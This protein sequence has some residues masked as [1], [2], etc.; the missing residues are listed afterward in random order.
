MIASRRFALSVAAVAC[1]AARGAPRCAESGPP[2][3]AQRRAGVLADVGRL[4]LELGDAESVRG[5]L[6]ALTE[7]ARLDPAN[8][9]ARYWLGVVYL[10][11]AA[12]GGGRLDPERVG[13]AGL[14]FEAVFKLSALDRSATARDLRRRAIAA[15]DACVGKLPPGEK[16]FGS[17]WKARR[18][19]LPADK[20]RTD[21]MH[22]IARG[23]TLATIARKY[24]GDARL[25]KR[26]AKANPGV[27]PRKLWIGKKIRV[28]DVARETPDPEPPLSRTDR[29]LVR[30]LRS[31]GTGAQRRIAAERLGE[32]DC[33][34]AVPRLIDALRSDPSQWVRTEAARALGRLSDAN[35]EPALAA[36]LGSDSSPWCRREAARALG[37]LGGRGSLRVLLGALSD[38]SSS[39]AAAAARALGR[40]KLARAGGPLV[41]A[42][43]VKSEALRCAAAAGLRDLASAG[44][45]TRG[46]LAGVRKLAAGAASP[47]RAAAL[48]ALVGGDPGAAEKLLPE[49]LGDN[50]RAVRRAGC[51]VAALLAAGGGGLE[52]RVIERLVALQGSADPA[53]RF[54]AALAVARVR[55][56]KGEG[57]ESLRKLIEML[58]EGRAIRW[59]GDEPRPVSDLALEALREITGRQLPPDGEVWRKWL[60]AN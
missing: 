31:A 16:R 59:G 53:V 55:R 40:R 5:A 10:R 19:K 28:P 20:P 25:A 11:A 60:K 52:R 39:V 17:W 12:A 15:L 50:A 18:A 42:L 30:R 8:I 23:D 36:A 58:G 9:R 35:A 21:M 32:R 7:A 29:E 27:D 26:I 34:A 22:T 49:A 24:Y 37:R 57:R 2:R 43:S 48:L 14:E 1:L 46:H 13:R 38:S 44:L 51:E 41:V 47:I 45:L 33:L 4:K 6:V 56:G 3:N 54:G